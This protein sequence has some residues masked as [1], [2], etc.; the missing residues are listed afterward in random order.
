MSPPTSFVTA[1][2]S[3]LTSALYD[4]CSLEKELGRG[5]MADASRH[6]DPELQCVRRRGEPSTRAPGP[7]AQT[8]NLLVET[9]QKDLSGGDRSARLRS[10]A[11]LREPT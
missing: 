9:G 4:R 5:G 3:P 8:V 11:A 6:A 2:D 10:A 1:I 7:R